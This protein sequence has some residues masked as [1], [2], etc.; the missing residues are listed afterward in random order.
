MP[1]IDTVFPQIVSSASLP[2]VVAVTTAGESVTI[3]VEVSLNSQTILATN[4]YA[5][6]HQA[7]LYDFRSVIEDVMHSEKLPCAECDIAV[8][9]DGQTVG[10]GGFTVI[11]SEFDIAEM[12]TWLS[13]HF[14]TTRTAQRIASNGLQSLYFYATQQERITYTIEAIVDNGSSQVTASWT[15]QS[16]QNVNK[17]VHQTSV[18]AQAVMNHFQQQGTVLAFKVNRGA[19]RSMW[20]YITDEYPTKVFRFYNAFNVTEYAPLYAATTKHHKMEATEAHCATGI[21]KVDYERNNE[22]EVKTAL[23]P[24]E[25]AKWLEQLLSSRFVELKG[26]D[27]IWRE[28]VIDGESEVTD[29]TEEENRLSFSYKFVKDLEVL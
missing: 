26:D 12:G 24:M 6:G 11:F 21:V 23:L 16:A 1:T 18:D 20:F 10:T 28:V 19:S 27:N 8:T 17:G 3:A 13:T 2:D 7:S 4:L 14:L 22:Y 15:Q 9:E 25:E 5:Y 29:N